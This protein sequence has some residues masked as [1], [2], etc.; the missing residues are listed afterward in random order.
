ME[1][2]VEPK[3]PPPGWADDSL[4]EYIEN[5]YRQ[6]FATFANK[7]DWFQR[8]ARLDRCFLRVVKDWINPPDILTP[9]LFIR[10]HSAY[11]VACEHAWQAKLPKLFH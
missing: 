11:R 1:E 6:R 8:L 2:G 5:A 7:R 10:C 9:L 3:L 4:T